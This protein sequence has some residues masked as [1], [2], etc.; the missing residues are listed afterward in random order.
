MIDPL[1]IHH[2][3]FITKVSLITTAVLSDHLCTCASN[4]TTSFFFNL[5]E[6]NFSHLLACWAAIDGKLGFFIA[7]HRWAIARQCTWPRT[8]PSDHQTYFHVHESIKQISRSMFLLLVNRVARREIVRVC[9]A[10]EREANGGGKGKYEKHETFSERKAKTVLV[11]NVTLNVEDIKRINF[12]S[13]RCA[14]KNSFCSHFF[15][16][17]IHCRADKFFIF[18][19][20]FFL[21]IPMLVQW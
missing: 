2:H 20:A 16:V 21:F 11:L 3:Y 4:P 13:S 8:F 9:G 1:K 5:F 7:I 6:I 18:R 12:P 15:R 19:L 14:D 10:N 17:L